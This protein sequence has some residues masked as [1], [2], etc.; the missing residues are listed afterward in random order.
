VSQE[1]LTTAEAARLAGVGASSVKRWADLNLL[2]CVRTPGGHRRFHRQD[3]DAFLREQGEL[4]VGAA[5]D[6]V[7]TLL[8]GG[9]FE[10]QGALFRARDRLGAWHAVAEE[11]GLA[12]GELGERWQ[13]GEVTV[14]E[15]H[16]A[17]E[18]LSR[19]LQRAAETIPSTEGDPRSLLA[20]AEDDEHTLGLSLVELCLRETGWRTV[21]S[22]RKTPTKDLV[23]LARSGSFEMLALSASRASTNE[24]RLAAQAAEL[25]AACRKAGLLL[26]FGGSG[27][28]PDNPPYG[29]RIQSLRALHRLA[30]SWRASVGPAAG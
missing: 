21:W 20:T 18:K 9:T 16:I 28:W 29:C 4:V 6:W 15:E 22:G 25:G 11:L 19:G 8:H 2:R 12:L 10:I 5:V 1:L 13:R 14:I 23:E 30:T 26:A 3:L 27:A 7:E 24:K 17:S